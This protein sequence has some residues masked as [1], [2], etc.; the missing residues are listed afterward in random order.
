MSANRAKGKALCI[1]LIKTFLENLNRGSRSN[2]SKKLI[3]VFGD[4]IPLK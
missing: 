2:D 3:L 4:P 1:N